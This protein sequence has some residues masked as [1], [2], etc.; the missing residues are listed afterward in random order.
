MKKNST[1]LSFSVLFEDNHLIAVKKLSGD[2]IQ[3]DKTG[4][5]T[6]AEN[7]K[8][9]IKKKYN[10]T[11]KYVAGMV[12]RFH[13]G[14]DYSSYLKLAE[15]ILKTRQDVTFVTIGDGQ[16]FNHFLNC[17]P[18]HIK[19]NFKNL[20]PKS[21]LVQSTI[22]TMTQENITKLI[23]DCYIELENNPLSTP[24]ANYFIKQLHLL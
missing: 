18:N 24:R 20:G 21:K 1:N 22:K 8:A 2:I 16:N 17:V 14:K 5:V 10:I 3:S 12:A 23:K 9:Y 6:L 13:P 19:P 4:D 15:T 11:T 7:V